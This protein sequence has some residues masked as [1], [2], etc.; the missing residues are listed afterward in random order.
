MKDKRPLIFLCTG[1]SLDGKLS[2]YKKE[3]ID[4]CTDD[5]KKF[6]EG[7]KIIAD[8]VMVGG[9]TLLQD[10]PALTVKT[11]ERQ[12]K[13]IKLGKPPEPIKVGVISNANNLTIRGDF[14]DRGNALK[15]IFTTAQTSKKK[16]DELKRK[17]Q[18]YV[19]GNKMV[20]LKRAMAI[21]YKLG[22]KRLMV[23]GGG[24]LIFSLLKENLVDE[25]NL[26]IGNLIV[27]GKDSITFVEG[28]G[29]DKITAKGVRLIKVIKRPNYIA[30][31]AKIIK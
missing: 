15:I 26:K 1:M 24:T 12:Q 31:K 10:D 3:Q 25:I 13:R 30:L 28:Q 5:D 7:Y 22:V 23:E 14:F 17:A 6:R 2:N 27:G 20:N 8:A 29:F 16:L 4:I 11:K 19:L 21:L 18:V 9:N